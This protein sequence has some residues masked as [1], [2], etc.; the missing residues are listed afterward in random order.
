VA[1]GDDA[2][3]AELTRIR[4]ELDALDSEL[5]QV[6]KRRLDLGLE[7]ASVKSELGIPMHD[8]EREERAVRQAGDWARSSDLPVAEVEE[9]FRRLISL[10]RNLQIDVRGDQ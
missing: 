10:S 7:A 1:L 5:I 4:A 3:R 6:I 2:L 8:P 9:I